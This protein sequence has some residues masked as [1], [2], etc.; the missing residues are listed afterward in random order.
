M[1]YVRVHLFR[2]EEMHLFYVLMGVEWSAIVEWK[3]ILGNRYKKKSHKKLMTLFAL[4]D[5]LEL[6]MLKSNGLYRNCK[7]HKIR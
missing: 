3:S 5:G 2:K 4:Q 1:K 6:Y 7:T